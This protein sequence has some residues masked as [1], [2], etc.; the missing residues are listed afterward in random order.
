MTRGQLL[1]IKRQQPLFHA[2]SIEETNQEHDLPNT[3]EYLVVTDADESYTFYYPKS[4]PFDKSTLLGLIDY[5]IDNE[6][7]GAKER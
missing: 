4:Q 5:F 6:L 2:I 3:I 7:V 1:R